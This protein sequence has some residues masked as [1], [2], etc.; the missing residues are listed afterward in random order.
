MRKTMMIGLVLV[1]LFTTTSLAYSWC[2]G[3][4]YGCMT[5]PTC[6]GLGT[7]FHEEEFGTGSTK[8]CLYYL[9]C[10]RGHVWTCA[11]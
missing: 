6:G 7:V 5:C 3:T 8:T 10:W 2:V 9:K 11:N 1:A 4:P